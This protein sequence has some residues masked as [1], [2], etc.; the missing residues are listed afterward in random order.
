MNNNIN[1][2]NET[3][4]LILIA[5]DDRTTRMLLKML[6]KKDEYEVIEVENGQQCLEKY[7]EL[8]PDVILLD[9]LMPIMDGFEC[10]A[11]LQDLPNGAQTPVLM[12]TALDDQKSVDRAFAAGAI[13]YVTKPLH[14]PLLR[15]RLRRILQASKAETALRESEKKYRSVVNSLKE[16]I[17]QT[18]EQG[19]LIFL[20]P[21]WET[22]T[23]FSI[24]ES[25]GKDFQHFIHPSDSELHQKFFLPLIEQNK[26]KT[27]EDNTQYQRYQIRFLQKNKSVCW[28]EIYV[29]SIQ[30]NHNIFV[31]SGTINDITERKLRE[32]YLKIENDI[33]KTLAE[34]DNIEQANLEIL[35]NIGSQLDW[36]WGEVWFIDSGTNQIK[37]LTIWV[38]SCL[39]NKIEKEILN[40]FKQVTKNHI[41]NP[42]NESIKDILN[43]NASIV[44]DNLQEEKYFLRRQEII[45][46]GLTN[47]ISF[48]IIGGD[49]KLGIINFFRSVKTKP[50]T[51]ILKLMNSLG[52]Q[53]GQFIRRKMAEE[54]L[55][56]QNELLQSE[57][58][59]AAD[60]VKSLL[61][62]PL[63]EKILINQ[64]FIPSLELGGDAFDYYWLDEENLT[65]YLLDVAGH[66]VQSAL[67][68]VSILNI[69]RSQ[70]LYN[71]D[72]YQPWTILEELN[73]IFQMDDN[74]QNYFTIWY[75]VYNVVSKELV[76]ACGGHP[77]AILIAPDGKIQKVGAMSI[78]IG[79]LPNLEFEEHL[80]EIPSGS[81]MYIFSDGIYEIYLENNNIWGIDALIEL[82]SQ[83]YQLNKNIELSQLIEKIKDIT[84]TQVFNDD[85][86]I[87]QIHF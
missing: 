83:E 26:P 54:E 50:E 58:N 2:L 40:K 70:A 79:M 64:N 15:Q 69:L 61:P 75:G 5:D 82:I 41:F 56:K 27:L 66:G 20:N 29:N 62:H 19:K 28:V 7:N 43:S 35:K 14:P 47:C 86:S 1:N 45:D 10:C 3:P 12:I 38:N 44:L 81:T 9:A 76:Y 16:I 18:D 84:K 24:A 6:L 48:P 32:R 55:Q 34:S 71:T 87:L 68:S 80:F 57:L 78:P 65:I 77:P 13:D 30:K 63:K 72:F 39:E 85:V 73:R 33:R 36:Q 46:A 60:Y 53:I 42:E 52:N 8:R 74:G 4:S 23:G 59:K 67:L 31:T 25:L 17:F 51:E 11:R 37:C 22:I 49:R 21:A